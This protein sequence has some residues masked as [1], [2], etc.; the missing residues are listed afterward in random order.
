MI[1]EVCIYIAI[2]L[3]FVLYLYDELKKE[4]YLTSCFEA[5]LLGIC[6][7]FLWLPYILFVMV[8]RIFFYFVD[9]E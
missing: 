1:G 8:V 5:I 3:S 7:V 6:I 9:K 4:C 2:G